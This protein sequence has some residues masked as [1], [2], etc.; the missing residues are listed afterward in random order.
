MGGTVL[1]GTGQ[2]VEIRPLSEFLINWIFRASQNANRW[3]I[4]NQMFAKFPPL[5]AR[6]KK[7]CKRSLKSLRL[8]AP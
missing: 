4:I 8:A 7:I 1:V 2:T 6:V 5:D 3:H